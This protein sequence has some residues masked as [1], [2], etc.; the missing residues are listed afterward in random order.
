MRPEGSWW[1]VAEWCRISSPM[2]WGGAA[3]TISG[4]AAFAVTAFSC[5]R[6]DRLRKRGSPASVGRT[7]AAAVGARHRPLPRRPAPAAPGPGAAGAGPG[8]PA[9]GGPGVRR[10]TGAGLLPDRGCSARVDGVDVRRGAPGSASLLRACR[11]RR[12]CRTHRGHHL[13]STWGSRAA[14][15][16]TSTS[17]ASRRRRNGPAASWARTGGVVASSSR[18]TTGRDCQDGP[19][20]APAHRPRPPHRR[21]PGRGPAVPR[22]VRDPLRSRDD[23]GQRSARS[24]AEPPAPVARGSSGPPAHLTGMRAPVVECRRGRAPLV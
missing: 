24:S 18:S 20:R 4:D 10:A 6:A 15:V 21:P 8:G 9:G 5:T 2:S 17:T 3:P 1:F 22:A 16:P 19:V 13:V 12:P 14:V 23:R 7:V 11:R